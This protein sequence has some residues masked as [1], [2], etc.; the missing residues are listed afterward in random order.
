MQVRSREGVRT[1]REQAVAL[2]KELLANN[3]I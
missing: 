2:V 1:L 3:L